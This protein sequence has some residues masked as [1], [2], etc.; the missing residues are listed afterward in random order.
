MAWPTGFGNAVDAISGGGGACS[1]LRVGI[2]DP[3]QGPTLTVTKGGVA[4]A[5]A[6]TAG[7]VYKYMVTDT[8]VWT[9]TTDALSQ[10]VDVAELFRVYEVVGDVPPMIEGVFFISYDKG[11]YAQFSSRRLTRVYPS[12]TPILIGFAKTNSGYACPVF[13]AGR[14]LGAVEEVIT[15]DYMT[16]AVGKFSDGS[17]MVLYGGFNGGMPNAAVSIYHNGL[18]V[19]TI[20]F[21]G[22]Q[23]NMPYPSDRP[24]INCADPSL[25][26]L[27]EN[28]IRYCSS[29]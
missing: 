13:T 2:A 8:G 12:G 26:K 14:D 19:V 28:A 27:T 23:V 5:P 6:D 7:G 15:G 22:T 21:S 20:P 10:E 24:Y 18:N 29:N 17:D 3:T 9:V 4:L 16:K 11:D 25:L 1:F